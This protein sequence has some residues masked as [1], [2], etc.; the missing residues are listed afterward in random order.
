MHRDIKAEAPALEQL[1]RDYAADPA[2][3]F[4]AGYR[5]KGGGMTDALLSAGPGGREPMPLTVA[6]W[7]RA[8]VARDFPGAR[9]RVVAMVGDA[10]LEF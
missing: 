7:L 6:D 3:G 10:E 9:C 8:I 2:K 4:A 1:A 5:P